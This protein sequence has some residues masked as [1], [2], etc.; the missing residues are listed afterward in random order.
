MPAGGDGGSARENDR[1]AFVAD[2]LAKKQRAAGGGG[3]VQSGPRKGKPNIILV[4]VESVGGKQVFNTDG[5]D[6]GA[7]GVYNPAVTPVLH[8]LRDSSVIFPQLLVHF[9]A[10]A[11]SHHET[12]TGGRVITWYVFFFFCLLLL[13]SPPPPLC[14]LCLP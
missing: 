9:P 4:T 14:R 7:A 5:P 3:G 8:S 13:S 11:R 6:G 12:N 2:F 10:S 1:L